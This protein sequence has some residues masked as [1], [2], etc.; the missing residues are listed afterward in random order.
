VLQVTRQVAAPGAESA[1]YECVVWLNTAG[2][3]R[4]LPG[5]AGPSTIT[6]STPTSLTV[7]HTPCSD[8]TTSHVTDRCA[9]PQ[10]GATI[11]LRQAQIDA[12]TDG[13]RPHRCRHLPNIVENIDRTPVTRYSPPVQWAGGCHPLPH[14]LPLPLGRSAGPM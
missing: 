4:V 2:A 8:V 13:E 9:E 14:K 1:L 5:L 12:S 3:K 7:R 10:C 6:R 11:N